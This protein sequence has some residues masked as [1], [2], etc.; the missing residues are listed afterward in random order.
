MKSSFAEGAG[1]TASPQRREIS[2]LE[3][4]ELIKQLLTRTI[5]HIARLKVVCE[6]RSD[7]AI[8]SN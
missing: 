7:E 2:I 4:I 1:E 3:S 8:Q 6:E 5:V